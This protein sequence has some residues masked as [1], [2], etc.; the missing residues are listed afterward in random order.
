MSLNYRDSL[1]QIEVLSQNSDHLERDTESHAKISTHS[2]DAADDIETKYS[3]RFF[4][5]GFVL[6]F[7]LVIIFAGKPVW[8]R[9]GAWFS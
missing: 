9:I 3:M 4:W 2:S 5:V 7:N 6:S 8:K 1:D